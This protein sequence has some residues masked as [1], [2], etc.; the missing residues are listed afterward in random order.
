MSHAT[1]GTDTLTDIDGLWFYREAAWYSVDDA[2]RL[3]DGAPEFRL[4]AD[5][6]LNGTTG[7]DRMIGDAGD[8]FYYGGTGNDFYNG[9]EGYNQVNFDGA[10]FEYTITQNDNGSYTFEHPVWGT[11][12]L[13]NID[14]LWLGGEAQWYA[15]DDGLLA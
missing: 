8:D 12:T 6:V 9:N 14:G 4:D 3:S 1:W 5:G 10:L 2:I 7:D 11:D 13:T 15:V